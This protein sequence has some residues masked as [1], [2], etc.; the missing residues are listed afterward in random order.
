MRRKGPADLMVAGSLESRMM[1]ERH[2][3]KSDH[4]DD[5]KDG[6]NEI[7]LKRWPIA[8]I[9]KICSIDFVCLHPSNEN[10]GMCIVFH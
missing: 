1:F 8:H 2:K 6:N 5:D 4:D 7:R 9:T 10:M 3:R